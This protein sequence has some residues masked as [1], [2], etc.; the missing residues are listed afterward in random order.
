M[1]KKIFLS[2]LLLAA[3]SYAGNAQ[4]STGKPSA[5]EI[6]TGNR[7]QKGDFGLYISPVGKNSIESWKTG[8]SYPLPI[9][10]LKYFSSD[11]FELRVGIDSKVSGDWLNGKLQNA[12]EKIGN[13]TSE[14]YFFLE[15]GFAY[16][17]TKHNILDVYFGAE[18]PIGLDGQSSHQFNKA[19]DTKTSVSSTCFILG[20]KPVIGLQ[21]FVANLPL[22]IGLEYG[23]CGYIRAGQKF[24]TVYESGADKQV[25][26][27]TTKETGTRYDSLSSGHFGIDN[28]V[29]LVISYY[30]K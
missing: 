6:R 18:L 5:K 8:T 29:R 10:N 9:I 22:A 7:P 25:Y 3:F 12:S 11:N 16:H 23:F 24:K 27:S 26:Y 17:C 14:S 19:S 13:T 4:L 28:E 20:L 21:C 2:I 1:K 30:F 15:P